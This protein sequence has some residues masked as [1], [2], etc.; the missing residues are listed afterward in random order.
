MTEREWATYNNRAAARRAAARRVH[1]DRGGDPAELMAAF[2][3]IDTLFGP[4]RTAR[5]AS[6]V[7]VFHRSRMPLGWRIHRTRLRTRWRR[8]YVDI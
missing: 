1:P 7:T 4:F 6:P 2:A 3:D 8:R 5:P